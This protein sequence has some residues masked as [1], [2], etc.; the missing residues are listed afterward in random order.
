MLLAIIINMAI[1]YSAQA[2]E[3]TVNR[4]SGSSFWSDASGSLTG[5][6]T[7]VSSDTNGWAFRW[8]LVPGEINTTRCT[9][10][11]KG[12]VD[13]SSLGMYPKVG[14]KIADGVILYF[15]QG[16]LEN[17]LTL[18][19]P[20]QL[21]ATASLNVDGTM[22]NL[23][24][25]S[26]G[27][28]QKLCASVPENTSI[29]KGAIVNTS[30]TN[31][32]LAV[33]VDKSAKPGTY[34]IPSVK[35]VANIGDSILSSVV[36]AGGKLIV[37]YPP[38]S[39][40][41]LMPPNIDFGNV[42]IWEWEGNTSGNLREKEYNVLKSI[43]GELTI[44]CTGDNDVRAPAKLTLTKIGTKEGYANDL[45]MMMDATNEIAPAVVRASIKSIFPPCSAEGIYFYSGKVK[46]K[47]NIVD[48]GS[49]SSG[50]N[51]IPYRFS[52]CSYGEGFK[53][54]SASASATITIDWE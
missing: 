26:S 47:G 48:L 45:L 5:E 38:L 3:L 44:T 34:N 23:T 17:S 35:L 24:N 52:L 18:T 40:S 29:E 32:K 30:L 49:I 1:V 4:G 19:K 14:M 11:T 9:D 43:D 46:P 21:K 2:I 8:N 16:N 41:I 39:C 28:D 25:S 12:F 15:T 7:R 6:H 10:S 36:A 42:N 37:K 13:T 50:Q 51:I 20:Q 27:Y 22:S 33:Y 54:G 53:S 31:G